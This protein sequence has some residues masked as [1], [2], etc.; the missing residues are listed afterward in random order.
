MTRLVTTRVEKETTT[1]PPTH[2]HKVVFFHL[3]YK[4]IHRS[5]II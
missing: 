3:L 2:F 1:A 4:V 5:L